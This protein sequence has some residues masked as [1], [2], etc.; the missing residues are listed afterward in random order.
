MKGL[1]CSVLRCGQYRDGS[2]GGATANVN[3]VTLIGDG[4]RGPFEPDEDAPAL[5]LEYDL[6]PKGVRGGYLMVANVAWLREL[7]IDKGPSGSFSCFGND[8]SERH[9]VV[10]VRA[11]PLVEG[12]PTCGMFGGNFITTSDSRFP[13][14]SPIPVFDRFE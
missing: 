13:M 1:H 3:S 5:W 14:T 7:G 10:R 11:V 8:W 6:N 4:V 9:Q 2:N 12:E